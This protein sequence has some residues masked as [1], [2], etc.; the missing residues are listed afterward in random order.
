MKLYSLIHKWLTWSLLIIPKITYLPFE[1]IYAD[2]YIQK[3]NKLGV[4]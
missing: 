4:T 3:A 1:Y 2:I